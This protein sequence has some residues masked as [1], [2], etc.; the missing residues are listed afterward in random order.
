MPYKIIKQDCKQA[1]G[2]DGEYILTKAD[3]GQ[4]VSCHATEEMAK[5]AI[6]ARHMREGMFLQEAKNIIKESLLRKDSYR[7]NDLSRL[8]RKYPAKP[9][10]VSK[11]K[12][13]LNDKHPKNNLE[14][15]A[16]PTA[17]VIISRIDNKLT[18]IDGFERLQSA[19]DAG[20]S[21]IMAIRLLRSEI[22][23]FA[24]F[25]RDNIKDYKNFYNKDSKNVKKH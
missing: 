7:V 9:V 10:K 18:V 17:P 22:K 19:V 21:H 4:K 20:R 25:R 8:A 6:K 5:K 3:T 15:K 16:P 11:L 1:N 24:K 14:F 2:K 23:S 12:W 13:I